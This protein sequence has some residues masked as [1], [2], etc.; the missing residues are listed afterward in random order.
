MDKF[1]GDF[2]HLTIN[3]QIAHM[4]GHQ[5]FNT[6]SRSNASHVSS[7]RVDLK[8]REHARVGIRADRQVPPTE[9]QCY[10]KPQLSGVQVMTQVR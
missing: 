5:S 7:G 3:A 4:A 10:Y 1:L 9:G 2:K 6:T 8:L